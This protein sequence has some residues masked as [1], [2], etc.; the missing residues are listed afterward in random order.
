[1]SLVIILLKQN[2]L[3]LLYLVVGYFLFCKKLVSVQGSAD[4][5]RMLLYIVMPM[6]I[7]KS[8]LTD[9]SVEKLIGLGI[10]AAGA[11]LSL[12][13]AILISRLLFKK[14]EDVERFGTAFSNAGFIGIPLVQMTLGA[15]AVFY[16]ASFVSLL[17][18]LQWTYGVVILSGNR[19]AIS[20]KKL[21]TNPILLSFVAGLICFGFSVQLPDMLTSFVGNLAAMNGPLA[22]IV[23][24]TYLAQTPLK[25]LFTE[26]IVYKTAAVRL[27]IIPILTVLLMF[28]FSKAYSTICLTILI[29]ASAPIGSN[30]AIFAQLYHRDYTQAVKEVCLSTLLCIATMPLIIGFA[31]ILYGIA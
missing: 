19:N 14:E 28:P 29:A 16:V 6:A 24:G 17:N 31:T 25:T 13:L 2:L 9:F 15:E 22:M 8:Y 11:A 7:L 30:V 1:M 4:L 3:M 21:R 5:G 26:K 12:L 18:I 27:I 10:S 20:V 23:L